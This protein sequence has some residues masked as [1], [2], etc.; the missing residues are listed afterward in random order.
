MIY[1]PT[2]WIED[3]DASSKRQLEPLASAAPFVW[4]RHY[5]AS[6][7]GR[8]EQSEYR[9]LRFEK[10][11]K[12]FEK[13]DESFDFE[14][15]AVIGESTRLIHLNTIEALFLVFSNIPDDDIE[16]DPPLEIVLDT[17][18]KVTEFRQNQPNQ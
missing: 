5:F 16:N 7:Y 17:V 14:E 11:M 9:R 18:L 1:Q 2:E 12:W 15:A 6:K 4:S 3:F 13:H 8:N 10:A